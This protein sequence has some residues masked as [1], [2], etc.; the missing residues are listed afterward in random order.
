MVIVDKWSYP[1]L[2]LQGIILSINN[3]LAKYFLICRCSCLSSIVQQFGGINRSLVMGYAVAQPS[4]TFS[5]SPSPSL[6]IF[7]IDIQQAYSLKAYTVSTAWQVLPLCGRF[8][9]YFILRLRFLLSSSFSA[10]SFFLS[11]TVYMC[12]LFIES[13]GKFTLFYKP[14]KYTKYFCN[15]ITEKN[16]MFIKALVPRHFQGSVLNVFIYFL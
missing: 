9:C 10:S 1:Y 15:K 2:T 6:F 13:Y 4:P 14:K 8:Y 16:G 11:Y 5:P 12:K 7:V 3:S